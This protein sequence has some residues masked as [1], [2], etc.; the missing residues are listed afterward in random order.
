MTFAAARTVYGPAWNSSPPAFRYNL[1]ISDSVKPRVVTQFRRITPPAKV[2]ISDF[3]VAQIEHMIID[4]SLKPGD[5]LPPERELAQQLDVSRPSLREAILKLEARGLLQPRR[6]GG[7]QVV[8]VFAPTLTDP[9]VHLLKD[10]R[11]AIFDVLELR[12]ALEE[13]AAYYA[14]QRGSKAELETIKRCFAALDRRRNTDDDEVLEDAEADVAF[15][16]AIA[17]ASHNVALVY[18]MRGLFNLLRMTVSYGLDRLYREKQSFEIIQQQHQAILDA[19]IKRDP[20][21]A[22]NAAHI[23]LAFIDASLTELES[24]RSETSTEALETPERL[25]RRIRLD[26]NSRGSKL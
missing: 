22:R 26:R 17:E 7:A 13:V 23:H 16:M 15:H 24:V 8:D 3:I 19:V 2:R 21:A 20:D 6:G 10:N 14:A 4:G 11:D 5:P 1:R 18:V 12:H 9:L 25:L